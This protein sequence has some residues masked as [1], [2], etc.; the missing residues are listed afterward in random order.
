[1][2]CNLLGLSASALGNSGAWS[3][4]QGMFDWVDILE[5]KLDSMSPVGTDLETVKQ[6]IVEL[7]VG[8]LGLGTR[9]RENN[10]PLH[11]LTASSCYLFCETCNVT[12]AFVTAPP[13]SWA[14][15]FRVCTIAFRA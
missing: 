11:F 2:N 9:Q 8:R 4:T 15:R 6:Q 13:P 3:R 7:K 10:S 5:S 14:G 12:P 1:M